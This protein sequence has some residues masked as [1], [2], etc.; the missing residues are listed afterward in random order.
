MLRSQVIGQP[1]RVLYF[2]RDGGNVLVARDSMITMT[3]LG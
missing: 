2:I 3:R 1:R